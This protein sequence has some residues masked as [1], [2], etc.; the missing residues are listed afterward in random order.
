MSVSVTSVNLLEL[1]PGT[2]V[3]L[4]TQSGSQWFI[5]ITNAQQ[6]IAGLGGEWLF[7]LSVMTTSTGAKLDTHHPREF[8]GE[9]IITAG[10]NWRVGDGHTSPVTQIEID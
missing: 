10:R 2:I 7:G 9:S 5:T 8:C 4:T 6:E 3:T 1:D